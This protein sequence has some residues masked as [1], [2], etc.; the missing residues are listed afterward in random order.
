M[1]S[2][3]QKQR[4]QRE[5]AIKRVADLLFQEQGFSQT[6]V[7]DIAARA[8]VGVATIYKYFGSK[9]GILCQLL[10]PDITAIREAGE[11]VLMNPPL[12]PAEAVFKLVSSYKFGDHWA[13]K[14]LL[15]GLI[16]FD[17]GYGEPFEALRREVDAFIAM[18][19]RE[20]LLNASRQGKLRQG[21]DL[22]D[23]ATVIYAIL[24]HNFQD[25]I[26]AE[27]DMDNATYVERL[28]RHILL[29]F[30]GWRA[31]ATMAPARKKSLRRA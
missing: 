4:Q 20:L 25:Y 24:N 12:D 13:H 14:E 15:K 10:W 17:L 1:T 22:A 21:L 2:L 23:M 7:E 8:E 5:E 29:L 6:N 9:G 26:V 30:E 18:Q 11:Q 28:R 3:R 27:K 31:A 16:G 19:I